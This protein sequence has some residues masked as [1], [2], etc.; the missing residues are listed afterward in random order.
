MPKTIFLLNLL[1]VGFVILKSKKIFSKQQYANFIKFASAMRLLISTKTFEVDVLFCSEL[2]KKFC[3]ECLILYGKSFMSYNV[4]S[5]IHL[6]EDFK[7]FGSLDNVCCFPFES[8]LG[9]I[10]NYVKSGN[11]PLQQ[12]AFRAYH[13]NSNIVFMSRMDCFRAN[14]R[15]ANKMEGAPEFHKC[16][17]TRVCSHFR[18][19]Y[20]NSGC[21]ININSDADCTISLN[22]H[23]AKVVD[24]YICDGNKYLVIRK[25]QTVKNFF[26][27][28][29]NSKQVQIYKVSNLSDDYNIIAFSV[30]LYKCM[31]LP[32][33]Q[34]W[35]AI[36][37]LHNI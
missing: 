19:I 3:N 9:L 18:V 36:E 20:L 30:N 21:Q 23:I 34:H 24:A 13:E 11:N 16:S 28:P 10:K 33:K 25:Y 35:V 17:N 5:V 7:L 6:V 1:Y 29:F 4:H 26:K 32:Y 12:V 27:K 15:F 14:S 2:L 31:L 37:M 22:N 8:Y